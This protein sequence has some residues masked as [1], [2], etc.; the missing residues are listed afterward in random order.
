MRPKAPSLTCTG[1]PTILP[2][3]LAHAMWSLATN[4]RTSCN[5]WAAC[6]PRAQ[7]SDRPLP[8]PPHRPP[9]CI[10]APPEPPNI[11]SHSATA[12]VLNADI[13]TLA[14]AKDTLEIIPVKAVFESVIVILALVR[15]R[16]PFC[17]LACTHFSVIRLGQNDRRQCICRT[18][19]VLR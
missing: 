6:E 16:V 19:Q 10:M 18:G 9:S 2:P 14:V 11:G 12:A 8:H 7:L 1:R 4:A 3:H 15:V 13:E 17:P 5:M